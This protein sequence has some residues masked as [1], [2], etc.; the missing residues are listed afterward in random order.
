MTEA[1]AR[2]WIA[3]RYGEQRV[4]TLDRYVT[5]LLAEN[6]RQ[7]LI[8]KSSE[9]VVWA[10]HIVDSAQLDGLIGEARSCLDVG[11]GPGLPGIVL[12]ALSERPTLLVEPRRRRAEFL[13]EIIAALKLRNASV[14]QAEIGR[15]CDLTFDAVTARAYAPLTQI[16]SSTVQ[17]TTPSTIWVLPKGRSAERELEEAQQAWHGMFHVERSLTD[18]D[19]RI[20]VA[21]EVR[22]R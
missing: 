1:E 21:Q 4:A 8:S 22:A 5:L 9:K 19:A 15:V 14:L 12:A 11:S 18:A 20:V 13:Q 3:Q 16:F 17:L 10:R 7:N 6:Q 2:A